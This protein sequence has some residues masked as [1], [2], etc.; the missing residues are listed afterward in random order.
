MALSCKVSWQTF[1]DPK[2]LAFEG[3]FECSS[4]SSELIPHKCRDCCIKTDVS[5]KKNDLNTTKIWREHA[6]VHRAYIFFFG[7]NFKQIWALCKLRLLSLDVW[8]MI[9]RAKY[10]FD[11]INRNARSHPNTKVNAVWARSVLGW[12]TTREQCGVEFIFFTARSQ[13]RVGSC[14]FDRRS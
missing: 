2:M 12:G 8:N 10:G 6:V 14:K 7:Q 3:E 5:P 9:Q 4:R 1:V 11:H 13:K